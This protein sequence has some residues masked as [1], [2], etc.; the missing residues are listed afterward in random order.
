MRRPAVLVFVTAAALALV[1]CDGSSSGSWS[2]G[3]T[4]DSTSTS[5]TTAAAD[6]AGCLEGTWDLDEAV[7]TSVFRAGFLE[8]ISETEGAAAE[9]ASLT[10]SQ[11]VTFVDDETFT[12]E[13]RMTGAISA[14]FSGQTVA[15]DMVIEASSSGTWQVDG[16]EMAISTLEGAGTMTVTALGQTQTD[17]LGS[18]AG[19]VVMLPT[20][21][22][23][24]TCGGDRLTLADT[25]MSLY[26]P[27]APDEIVFTRQ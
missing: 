22:E 7:L 9:I 24:V 3:A 2:P 15:M 11:A 27:D 20:T 16:D 25:G 5:G 12:S 19:D 10:A 13:T 17:A 23:P 6:L 8:G 1:G 26:I 18:E 4:G 14:T 21:L